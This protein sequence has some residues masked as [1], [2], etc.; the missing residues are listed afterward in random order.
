MI[1]LATSTNTLSSALNSAMPLALRHA[2]SQALPMD[3]RLDAGLFWSFAEEAADE[4][5]DEIGDDL[6]GMV[7]GG[8]FTDRGFDLLCDAIDERFGDVDED[9]IQAWDYDIISDDYYDAILQ[10][11]MTPRDRV[12]AHLIEEV[13]AALL[14]R[15]ANLA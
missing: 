9:A 5:A 15:I 4:I 2:A 10:G 7:E 6:Y 12:L 3:P 8:E 14:C 13:E 11:D 1:S